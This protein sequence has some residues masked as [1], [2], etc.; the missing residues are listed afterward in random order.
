MRCLVVFHFF[1]FQPNHQMLF[2]FSVTLSPPPLKNLLKSETFY[3]ESAKRFNNFQLIE[4]N[5]VFKVCSL[6]A[7]WLTIGVG[8]NCAALHHSWPL[9]SK[10]ETTSS[11]PTD[12]PPLET[13]RASSLAAANSI[14]RLY[15]GVCIPPKFCPSNPLLLTSHTSD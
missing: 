7:E 4:Q 9:M 8:P 2:R 14:L 1:L 6:D 5:S 10:R 15:V 12:S 3:S 11:E 13:Y